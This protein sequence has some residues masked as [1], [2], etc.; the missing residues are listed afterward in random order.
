MLGRKKPI[1]KSNHLSNFGLLILQRGQQSTTE[2]VQQC[3]SNIRSRKLEKTCFGGHHTGLSFANGMGSNIQFVIQFKCQAMGHTCLRG[4]K[5]F[6]VI[7]LH[8]PVPKG[9]DSVREN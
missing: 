7:D 5:N 1:G 9:S 4:T 8:T 6:P 3:S 2:A